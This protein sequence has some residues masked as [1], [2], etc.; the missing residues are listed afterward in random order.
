[1]QKP[2]DRELKTDILKCFGDLALGLK[3]Y[4]ENYLD[5]IIEITE[6]CFEAV[7]TFSKQEQERAY[8]E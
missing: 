3:R 8:A 4:T 6:N 2:I 1:M 5:T 7:Y